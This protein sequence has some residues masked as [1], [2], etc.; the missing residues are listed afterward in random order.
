MK[1]EQEA[2]FPASNRGVDHTEEY[3]SLN[4]FLKKLIQYIHEYQASFI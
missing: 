2:D 3:I 1:V 4:A